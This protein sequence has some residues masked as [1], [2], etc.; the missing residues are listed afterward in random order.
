VTTTEKAA[1]S[2]SA[3][4]RWLAEQAA[5]ARAAGLAAAAA[6]TGMG[7]LQIAQAWLI[8][9][10][11]VS[12][13][14]GGLPFEAVTALVAVVAGR[15]ALAWVWDAAGAAAAARV[16][17]DLR[18]RLYRHIAG[19]GPGFVAGRGS[20]SLS[21][22]LM[23]QV[24]ALD[25][26]VARYRPQAFVAAAVPVAILAAVFPVD[27]VAGA[28][29]ALAAPIVPLLMAVAGAGAASE[30]QRQ[31]QALARMSGHFLDRLQG[32]VTLRLLGRAE[33]ELASV[34]QVADEFRR[35]TMSVLRLAF[36]SSAVLEFFTAVA[37]AMIAIYVGF[38]FL[39]WISFGPAPEM[40]LRS[41]LFVLLLAPEFFQPLR[42]LSAFY[43]DRAAA[44]GAAREL[45]PILAAMP[46]AQAAGPGL[47]PLPASPAASPAASRPSL[48]PGPAGLRLEDV[49]VTHAGRAPALRGVSFAVS[50][51]EH[52]ALVGPSG[53]GKTTILN[54]LLGFVPPERGRAL[55]GGT[56][57]GLLDDAALR[58]LVAWVG[59]TRHLFEGTLRDNI[60]L[61]APGASDAEI[62]RAAAL[63]HVADFAAA[64]P[65]GLDTRIGERGFG[66]SGGQVQRVALAR[67]FLSPA[68]ILLMDEPTASLDAGNE[69]LVL[70]SLTRLAEGRTVLVATHSPAVAAWA[71]RAVRLDS[72]R[73]LAEAAA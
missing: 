50:P 53:S 10:A 14:A 19:L 21:A 16:K 35:R 40:T 33:A 18:G 8:A 1:G 22:A 15:S 49:H 23:E 12:V 41:G 47:R 48:P 62:W 39:G 2:T 17:A 26:Y 51:G 3:E 61:G 72:G 46:R 9:S 29:L 68:P 66:L 6:G 25:G 43:H 67:A 56:P 52:V 36:L 58:R 13:A 4:R 27:W 73:I 38:A 20:G 31:L 57:V 59:Q 28:L 34:G 69:A 65:D 5:A 55:I 42:Q 7:L 64:L 70:E 44:M 60:R 63:A 11:I 54:L 24:E 71:D 32:L 30:S 45:M 37:I